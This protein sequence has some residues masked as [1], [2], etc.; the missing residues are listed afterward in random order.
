MSRKPKGCPLC[1]PDFKP[2]KEQRRLMDKG[3]I[4]AFSCDVTDRVGYLF[5]RSIYADAEVVQALA[6]LMFDGP[7][8]HEMKELV[9]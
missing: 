6:A 4:F 2:T 1:D 5:N 8:P 9:N 3:T 7:E